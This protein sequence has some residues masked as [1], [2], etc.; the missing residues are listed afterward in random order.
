[1]WVIENFWGGYRSFKV[2]PH[3]H[4]GPLRVGP[5]TTIAEQAVL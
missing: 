1:M 3:G 4:V 5:F 2:Q